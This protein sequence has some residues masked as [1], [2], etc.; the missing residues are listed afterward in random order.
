[1]K[2]AQTRNTFDSNARSEKRA[3]RRNLPAAI[4]PIRLRFGA[5][6]V[7]ATAASPAGLEPDIPCIRTTTDN[8]TRP[9]IS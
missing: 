1:M 4:D 8:S 5:A 6:A 2:P 3:S 9:Y 7:T